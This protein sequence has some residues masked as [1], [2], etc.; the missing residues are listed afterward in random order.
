MAEQVVAAPAKRIR[1]TGAGGLHFFP[2]VR[3]IRFLR[4]SLP[5]KILGI[6]RSRGNPTVLIPVLVFGQHL[7]LPQRYSRSNPIL[8]SIRTT[9]SPIDS[10]FRGDS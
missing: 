6:P 8:F 1:R 4:F 5:P 7:P 9:Y 3:R 10:L 2:G